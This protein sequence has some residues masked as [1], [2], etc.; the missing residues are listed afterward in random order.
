MRNDRWCWRFL[1]A[2]ILLVAAFWPVTTLSA[3][4]WSVCVVDEANNPVARVLV[5]ESYQ[6]YSAEMQGREEDLYTDTR[7]C[8]RFPAKSVR[9]SL[10]KRLTVFCSAALGGVHASFGPYAYVTA[11]SGQLRGDDVRGGYE[12]SWKGSPGQVDSM[13]VLRSH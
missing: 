5:R 3:P 13:L 8:V 1:I 7:G 6:N 9:S 10:M 12:F 2:A 11:F 4:L